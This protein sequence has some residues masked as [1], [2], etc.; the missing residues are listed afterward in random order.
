MKKIKKYLKRIIKLIQLEEMQILP[1]HVAF[2]IVLMI[3]PVFSLIGVLGSKLDVSKISLQLTN[4]VPNAVL[5][6]LESALTFNPK[7]FNVFLF[8]LFSVWLVSNGCKAI[9]LASNMLFKIK[10]TSNLKIILK[11]FQMVFMLFALIGFVIIVPI[12]GDFIMKFL[13]HHLRESGA[14]F[15][16]NLYHF[17]KYPIS[18][19]LMYF[20]IKFIYSIA[21]SEYISSKYMRKG[22]WFTTISWLILSRIYSFHLNNYSKYSL[23]YGNLSNIL[24]LLVWVYLMAYIFTIGLS[25]NADDY[26]TYKDKNM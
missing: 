12:F 18:I 11:S 7:G 5:N 22:A 17:L 25:L 10:N 24:I 3:V 4:N 16:D 15:I 1:G 20:L 14:M 23:Y 8:T 19:I 2:N 21:P 26:L 13:S 9:I 6:I